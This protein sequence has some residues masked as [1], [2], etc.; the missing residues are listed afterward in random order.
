VRPKGLWIGIDLGTQ[1]VRAL[2]ATDRG[3]VV[4]AGAAPLASRRSKDRHEQ[5]PEAWW[6]ATGEACR[7]ALAGL[8]KPAEIGGVA[9][10]GTSGTVLLTDEAG[11][12]LTPGLMYDDARAADEAALANE[13]GAALWERL[14]YNRIQTVWALPKLIWMLRRERDGGR[15]YL[16]HQADF[17]TGRL[18]GKRLAADLGNALKTGCDTIAERWDMEVMD[19]LGVPGEVLPALARPGAPIGVVGRAG[20]AHTGIPAGTTIVAGMTDGCASQLSAGA[21]RAGDWNVVLGTTLV[22]KGKSSTLVR[23]PD[24]VVYSHRA[25][26]GQWLPGGASSSGA[27][28]LAQHLPGMDLEALS[29]QAARRASGGGV[30]YPLA[31]AQGERFPFV[32]PAAS[33][34][35]LDDPAGDALETYLALAN[36]LAAIERLC[37][38]YLD[39][40]GFP[41]DGRVSVTG[42]TSG[43]AHLN[44]VRATMLGR[45]LVAPRV[46]EPAFGMAVLASST[47]RPLSD[48][49]ASMVGIGRTYAPDARDAARC[50][51]LYLRLV[52]SLERRGWLPRET[53]DHAR[54]RLDR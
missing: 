45:E 5:D 22:L 26:D 28:A 12:A 35:F 46:A 53:A 18:A 43:N 13:H 21:M 11:G 24:G 23:D 17:V 27:G 9:V 16:A 49:V 40:L 31:S 33:G 34:F 15:R 51:D 30:A 10:C 8:A 32:A 25:P 4:G 6:T 54:K 7:A 41:T 52:E 20:A 48:A 14:G 50:A 29:G 1:S 19:R 39:L 36:G 47:A 37:F 44:R 2:A 3:E 38:D 42:G